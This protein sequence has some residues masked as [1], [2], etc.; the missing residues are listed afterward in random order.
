MLFKKLLISKNYKG[1]FKNEILPQNKIYLSGIRKDQGIIELEYTFLNIKRSL[2]VFREIFQVTQ[3]QP[4][5][6]I[7]FFI[8]DPLL[9]P[10]SSI[11]G[12][13]NTIQVITKK[14]VPGTLTQRYSNRNTVPLVVIFSQNNNISIAR[15]CKRLK[16]PTIFFSNL[17]FD[18]SSV[19]YAVPTN[20]KNIQSLYFLISLFKKTYE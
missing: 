7:L 14:W 16:I 18:L 19:D 2:Q 10:L 15:E 1:P 11:L 8:N 13:Q 3:Q 9:K 12:Y 4:K 6:K 17:N 20:E 5:S